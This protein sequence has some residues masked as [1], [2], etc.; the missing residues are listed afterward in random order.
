MRETGE[1]V[2]WDDDR[3]FGF[4]QRP[5]GSERI[6][7]HVKAIRQSYTRPR[8]GDR[9]SY[10]VGPG[11][12]GKLAALDVDI[13]GANP[14]PREAAQRGAP[15][16]PFA[17]NSNRVWAALTLIVLLMAAIITNRLPPWGA[18]PYILLGLLS[19][20]QYRADKLAAIAGVWRTSEY[21]LH[22]LDLAFGIIGGLLAQH[23]YRHK[24]SKP[25]FRIITWA[26]AALHMVLLALVLSGWITS[27][28]IK[29]SI[30]EVL[31]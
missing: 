12:N 19:F 23:I 9:L 15:E 3:G 22:G 27:E 6:F 2:D 4:I 17:R 25:M 26:I 16:L 28:L 13:A 14:R 5:T 24:T 29:A 10:T 7:V 31:R 1:L 8:L 21:Q 11:R 18:L 20:S 30:T